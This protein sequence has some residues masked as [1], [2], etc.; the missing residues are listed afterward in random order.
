[1]QERIYD[2]KIKD[3][4]FQKVKTCKIKNKGTP[5]DMKEKEKEIKIKKFGLI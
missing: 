1:M 5:A 2:D 3:D 4:T